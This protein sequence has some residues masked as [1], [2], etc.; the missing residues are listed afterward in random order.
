MDDGICCLANSDGGLSVMEAGSMTFGILIR[1]PVRGLR[2]GAGCSGFGVKIR[3][4]EIRRW[5]A[6]G[7][8]CEVE[9][10]ESDR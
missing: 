9:A 3:G 5:R 6:R 2:K 4:V 8:K 10:E 1:R 7:W